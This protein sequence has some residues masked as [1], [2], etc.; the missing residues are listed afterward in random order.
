MIAREI[1]VQILGKHFNF[2]IPDNIKTDDFLEVVDYVESKFKKI[3]N[4]Q[5]RNNGF[6]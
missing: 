6:L 5:P 2:S 4:R 1:E 3:K